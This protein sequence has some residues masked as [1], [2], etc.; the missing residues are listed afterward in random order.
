MDMASSSGAGGTNICDD[1]SPLDTLANMYSIFTIMGIIG[2]KTMTVGNHNNITS[3]SV[4][5]GKDDNS[6]GRCPDGSAGIGRN[7][8]TPVKFGISRNRMDSIAKGG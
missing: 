4:P 8:K 2:G 3:A 6:V 1:I 5:T 7:I